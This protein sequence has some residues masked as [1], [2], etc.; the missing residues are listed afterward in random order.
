[1][2][3][4]SSS[5]TLLPVRPPNPP[6]RLAAAREAAPPGPL[7]MFGHSAGTEC[8]GPLRRSCVCPPRAM[9]ALA[10]PLGSSSQALV[11][12]FPP[13]VRHVQGKETINDVIMLYYTGIFCAWCCSSP[14]VAPRVL[15]LPC[16]LTRAAAPRRDC[17]STAGPCKSQPANLLVNAQISPSRIQENRCQCTVCRRYRCH[18][19]PYP[20]CCDGAFCL[21]RAQWVCVFGY[22]RVFYI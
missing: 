20:T 2:A 19:C 1:M 12:H 5:H 15:Q 4:A 21:G 8:R 7:C 17:A 14:A 11:K 9:A 16:S 10:A 3:M 22:P 6:R 18:G 13:S